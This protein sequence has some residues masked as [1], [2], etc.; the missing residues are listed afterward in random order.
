MSGSPHLNPDA[1]P[2]LQRFSD[3]LRCL[4]NFRVDVIMTVESS[5]RGMTIPKMLDTKH[6][7]TIERP[8]KLAL[9]LIEGKI[10]TTVVCDGKKIY[11]YWGRDEYSESDAPAALDDIVI[12]C[13]TEN[14]IRIPEI[15]GPRCIDVLIC[16]DPY[17]RLTKSVSQMQYLGTRRVDG[18]ECHHI[19]LLRESYD[20]ELWIEVG[21]DPLLRQ[22]V[23][24][25]SQRLEQAVALNPVMKDMTMESSVA[26]K[27]WQVNVDLSKDEFRFVPPEGA[28]IVDEQALYKKMSTCE[29]CG[30]PA[31]V[32]E[33]NVVS[34]GT[35]TQEISSHHF[36]RACADAEGWLEKEKRFGPR[37]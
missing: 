13:A 29:K 33:S 31:E 34:D 11:K 15:C 16:H 23:P 37:E 30:Q 22:F 12:S 21:D 35:A 7:L 4:K 19:K 3:W 24:D 20:C 25:E 14:A 28:E 26:F 10:G 8:H 2:I 36:C 32:H 5:I 9:R 6:A 17:E 27:N 18:V 1:E